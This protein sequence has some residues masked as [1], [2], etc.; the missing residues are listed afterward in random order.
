[1]APR[2]RILMPD[3]FRE[4]FVYNDNREL[5][6]D[7]G[8]EVVAVGSEVIYRSMVCE[9][10]GSFEGIDG[11]RYAELLVKGALGGNITVQVEGKYEN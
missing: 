9:V 6:A 8:R 11:D 7:V 10:L 4:Y 3:G 2:V 5:G 1:M